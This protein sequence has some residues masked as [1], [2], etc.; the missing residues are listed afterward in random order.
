MESK[1]LSGMLVSFTPHDMMQIRK[2]IVINTSHIE[3]VFE[4]FAGEVWI[5]TV[6]GQH[7]E[8]AESLD[9]VLKKISQ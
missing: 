3:S 6:S 9:E 7:I 4:N 8:V 5:D 1:I 2:T